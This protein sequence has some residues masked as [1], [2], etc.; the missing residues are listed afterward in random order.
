M[1]GVINNNKFL[2]TTALTRWN[3]FENLR[4][5]RKKKQKK[6]LF[7]LAFGNNLDTVNRNFNKTACIFFTFH[8]NNVAQFHVIFP[9]TGLTI[10][11]CQNLFWFF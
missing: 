7:F 11:E 10:S 2:Q 6:T 1:P 9:S 5:D 3:V 8:Q 4:P